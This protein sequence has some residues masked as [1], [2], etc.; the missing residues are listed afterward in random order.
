MQTYYYLK[1]WCSYMD[2]TVSD[3]LLFLILGMML[4]LG[5]YIFIK[6]NIV[7]GLLQ[8][9]LT[10]FA[11]YMVCMFLVSNKLYWE[12]EMK[13]WVRLMSSGFICHEGVSVVALM[14]LILVPA[15]IVITVKNLVSLKK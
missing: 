8:I 1:A 9:I 12:M 5:V 14:L 6:K 13:T 2:I 15:L 4:A 10:L 3:V 7:N 11:P